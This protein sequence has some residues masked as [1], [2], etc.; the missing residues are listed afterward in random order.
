MRSAPCMVCFCR[1]GGKKEISDWHGK[2]KGR[3]Q[4]SCSLGHPSWADR[5]AWYLGRLGKSDVQAKAPRAVEGLLVVDVAEGR[6]LHGH[7]LPLY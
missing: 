4:V 7:G 2:M 3:C 5:K 6:R 1:G